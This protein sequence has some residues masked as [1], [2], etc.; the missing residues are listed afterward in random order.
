MNGVNAKAFRFAL[1]KIDDGNLF[2][3]FAQDFL[4]Q[5]LGYEFIPAGGLRDRGIDGLEHTFHRNGQSRRIYQVSIEKDYSSKI[6][7]SLS[8][9][10]KNKIEYDQF[11]YVTNLI[12]PGKDVLIDELVGK[13]GKA[14][15]IY[16]VQWLEVHVNDSDQT[17]RAYQIFIDAYL[18]EFSR[19]GSI[20]IAAN[21]EEDP[22]VYAFL[23]QQWEEHRT[24]EG[25]DNILVDSLIM[26]A[27]EGTDP[28]KKILRTK[29]E[30]LAHIKRKI[31]FDPRV[32]HERT[33]GTLE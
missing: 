18:H 30:I 19:P 33:I 23:R 11:V 21:L 17:V 9:L 16:D 1:S 6:R 29:E 15:S 27:L 8:T 2:E 10:E 5:V 24:N 4:A 28:V 32:L 20:Y 22:R 14:V 3:K 7:K 25:L 31:K 12:I 13:Y 26:Y